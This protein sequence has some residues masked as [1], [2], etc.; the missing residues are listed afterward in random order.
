M[1]TRLKDLAS[2]MIQQREPILGPIWLK[3]RFNYARFAT[4]AHTLSLTAFTLPAKCVIHNVFVM[5]SVPFTGPGVTAATVSVGTAG[6]ASA[7]INGFD[8]KQAAGPTTY[9]ISQANQ[10]MQNAVNPANLY[11]ALNTTGANTSALT[12][13]QLEVA[14]LVSE[15]P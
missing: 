7:F 4:N 11:I 2:S 12:A 1:S 6:N 8:V 15:V 9:Q 10:V 5:H 3:A 14:L 13:G